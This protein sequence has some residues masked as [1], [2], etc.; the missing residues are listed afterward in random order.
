MTSGKQSPS[1]PGKPNISKPN[2]G[3][4]K[5]VRLVTLTTLCSISA[6]AAYHALQTF[7]Q[8]TRPKPT[9]P[10][11]D[12]NRAKPSP[13]AQAQAAISKPEKGASTLVQPKVV[14]PRLVQ[15]K[16]DRAVQLTP[17]P[18]PPRLTLRS[19]YQIPSRLLPVTRRSVATP[20]VLALRDRSALEDL[21]SIPLNTTLRDIDG[22]WAQYHID[23]LSDRGIIQGFPDG[24]FRPN[25]AIKAGEFNAM[26]QKAF[27]DG[28]APMSY[29]EF[30]SLSSGRG[31]ATRAEVAAFIYRNLLRNEPQMMVTS[32]RVQ[33]EVSR[34]GGYSL[35]AVSDARI[36]KGK[37]LPTV[38]RAIQQAGGS[39]A[40][41]NLRQVE[42]H[43]TT[44][45]GVQKVYK[46]DVET[47]V[48]TGDFSQDV[49]LQQDDKLVIP[50]NPPIAQAPIPSSSV[51]ASSLKPIA[52]PIPSAAVEFSPN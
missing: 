17:S 43:R 21:P 8:S 39:S 10:E 40:R 37:N 23:F 25:Q 1:N 42:I 35:A 51:P 18:V 30:Q 12:P 34:P 5:V 19:E 44:N 26:M 45:T 24:S 27:P 33:G 49:V 41:A 3:S 47:M 52:P 32:I 4:P 50:S 36:A 16:P 7:T 48:Q 46:V 6:I 20:E 29:R 31:S 13:P 22:H 11:T 15:P 2:I 28:K 38:G 14:Q 9:P